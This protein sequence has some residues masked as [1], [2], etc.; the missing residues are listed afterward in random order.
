MSDQDK[1]ISRRNKRE[2]RRRGEREE[3]IGKDEAMGE[4][5]RKGRRE[6]RVTRVIATPKYRSHTDTHRHTRGLN[7]CPCRGEPEPSPFSAPG[8]RARASS[9]PSVAG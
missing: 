2:E 8:T 1:Y 9:G 6:V 4:T 7:F 5:R 3:K